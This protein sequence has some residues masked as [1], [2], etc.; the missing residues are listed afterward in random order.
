[1]T[2]DLSV[3]GSINNIALSTLRG[4]A[5]SSMVKISVLEDRATV[6]EGRTVIL[7]MDASAYAGRLVSLET[8]TQNIDASSGYTTLTGVVN[9]GFLTLRTG[10]KGSTALASVETLGNEEIETTYANGNYTG[11]TTSYTFTTSQFYSGYDPYRAFGSSSGSWMCNSGDYSL[12]TGAYTG[13]ISTTDFQTGL[14]YAGDYIEV[15]FLTTTPYLSGVTFSIVT[16]THI[17]T[18]NAKVLYFMGGIKNS[19]NWKYLAS[20]TNPSNANR[21]G[22]SVTFTY[23]SY[24]YD[25]FRVVVNSCYLNASAKP[26]FPSLDSITLKGI[27]RIPSQ[28]VYVPQSIEIGLT[29]STNTIPTEQLRV[30]GNTTITEKLTIRDVDVSYNL[31]VGGIVSISG[32]PVYPKIGS[33]KNT[34]GVQFWDWTV[35][36]PSWVTEAVFIAKA[37]SCASTFSPQLQIT[38]TSSYNGYTFTPSGQNQWSGGIDL[39]WISMTGSI[40]TMVTLKRMVTDTTTWVVSG[41]S[42]AGTSNVAPLCGY[43]V[44]TNMTNI[45][46]TGGTVNI[47]GGGATLYYR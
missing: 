47:T 46:F 16:T 32:N 18:A 26:P 14:S 2:G 43:I 22:I 4:D 12:S 1:M 24:S 27:T 40:T 37:V 44:V 8:K 45:R 6:V 11:N 13:L 39:W 42:W 31:N 17:S 38:T 29:A 15:G 41:N 10:Y 20:Y 35:S 36:I 28:L 9:H 7:E 33:Y 34:T 5:S 21:G 25:T 3:A 30:N 23:T 19:T